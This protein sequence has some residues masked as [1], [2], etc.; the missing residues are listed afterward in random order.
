MSPGKSPARGD[1]SP[2]DIKN[3]VEIKDEEVK[4]PIHAQTS[5]PVSLFTYVIH[6]EKSSIVVK[7][8]IIK[9]CTAVKL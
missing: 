6:L 3:D 1:I 5:D 9:I 2:A 8:S 7:K 4:V